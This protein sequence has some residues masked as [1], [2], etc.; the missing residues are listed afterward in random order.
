MTDSLMTL[1]G[2]QIHVDAE[3]GAIRNA[4]GRWLREVLPDDTFQELRE[5]RCGARS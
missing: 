2:Y 1:H 4:A 3:T 5:G